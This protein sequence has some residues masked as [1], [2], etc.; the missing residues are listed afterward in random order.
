CSASR[1]LIRSRKNDLPVKTLHIPIMIAKI[2]SQPVEQFRMARRRSHHAEILS[3]FNEPGPKNFGPHPVHDYARGERIVATNSPFR[4]GQPIQ[5]CSCRK[6]WQKMLH[7][8]T[9]AFGARA[10]YPTIENVGVGES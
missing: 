9:D 3:G 6:A 4:E 7:A 8:W 2:D 1:L 5:R 10:E